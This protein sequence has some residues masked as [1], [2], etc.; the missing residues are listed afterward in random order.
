MG[1]MGT[2]VEEFRLGEPA[3]ICRWRL[4][5]TAL[6]LENRH[7][8][9]LSKRR[10]DGSAMDM[11]LV[12]WAK[13][14]IEWTLS[15]GAARYPDGVLM[16]AIDHSG[17]AAMSVG[18]YKEL[19][20]TK[21]PA[22]LGRI[23]LAEREAVASNV[24]PESLWLVRDGNIMWSLEDGHIPSG[25]ATLIED[26]AVTL[27]YKVTRTAGLLDDVR[28]KRV[29]FDEAFLVSDEH[30]VVCISGYNGSE[31]ERFAKSYSKLLE[32]TKAPRRLG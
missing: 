19:E 6:P 21:L 14:H 32:E 23:D 12:S 30:G 29:L 16:L 11:R 24:A 15:E 8:R 4:S 27:G 17:H 22:V 2:K 10:I 26:L 9:A 25:S 3:L 5:H 31:G 1:E 28:A 7:I 13:Q 20:S 18:P